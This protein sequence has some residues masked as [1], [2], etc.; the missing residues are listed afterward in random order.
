MLEIVLSHDEAIRI[1]S[2]VSVFCT[3]DNSSS[4]NQIIWYKKKHQSGG[5]NVIATGD[6]VSYST[7][8]LC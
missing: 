8:R 1:G 7:L 6:M 2:T 4:I 3:V 5:E